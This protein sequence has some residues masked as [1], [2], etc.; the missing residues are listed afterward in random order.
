VKIS[1]ALRNLQ[2]PI[3][4]ADRLIVQQLHSIPTM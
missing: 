2:N 4:N 1:S 3:I